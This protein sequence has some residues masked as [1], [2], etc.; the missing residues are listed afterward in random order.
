MEKFAMEPDMMA[1]IFNPS[2]PEVEAGG[3][4]V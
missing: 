4:L 1:H 2:P 3:F